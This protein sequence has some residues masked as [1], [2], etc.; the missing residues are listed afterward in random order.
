M[1]ALSIGVD[2]NIHTGYS[3]TNS[4]KL[5]PLVRGRILKGYVALVLMGSYSSIEHLFLSDFLI[6]Q[7]DH[8]QMGL[9]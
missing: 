5:L 2:F 1:T 7:L 8:N 6:A 3:D 9:V 4:I